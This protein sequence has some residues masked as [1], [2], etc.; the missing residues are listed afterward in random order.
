MDR[1]DHREGRRGLLLKTLDA[2]G[3]GFDS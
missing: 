2:L 1:A 3:M